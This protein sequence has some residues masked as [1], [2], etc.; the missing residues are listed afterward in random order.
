MFLVKLTFRASSFLAAWLQ[1]SPLP[2]LGT[3]VARIPSWGGG[4]GWLSSRSRLLPSTS[5]AHTFQLVTSILTLI[6]RQSNYV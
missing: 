4:G 3:G 1:A 5:L 2:D 6:T